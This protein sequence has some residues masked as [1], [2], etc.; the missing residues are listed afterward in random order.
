MTKAGRLKLRGTDRTG[1]RE[2]AAD[3]PCGIMSDRRRSPKTP[4]AAAIA[5]R[6]LTRGPIGA[7]LLYLITRIRRGHHLRPDPR[8]RWEPYD[9]A[10]SYPEAR[11]K[12]ERGE[13]GFIHRLR[14]IPRRKPA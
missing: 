7:P 11:D 8:L 4:A 13:K 6:D 10:T 5:S 2:G 14:R 3:K 1:P 12:C 9:V